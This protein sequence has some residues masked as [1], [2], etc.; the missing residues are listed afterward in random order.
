M[1]ILTLFA[2]IYNIRRTNADAAA[3]GDTFFTVHD[4]GCNQHIKLPQ[5]RLKKSIYLFFS[6]RGKF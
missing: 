5:K 1:Q 2:M 4:V 3:L 6:A